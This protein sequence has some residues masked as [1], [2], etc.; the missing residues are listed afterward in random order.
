MATL[1]EAVTASDRTLVVE[2]PVAT[3]TGG[4]LVRLED[5]LVRFGGYEAAHGAYLGTGAGNTHLDF[6]RWRVV[7]GVEGTTAVSHLAGVDVRRAVEAVGSSED[8]TPP[9]PFTSGGGGL[10]PQWAVDSDGGLAINYEDT[11]GSV[12]AVQVN[13]VGDPTDYIPLLQLGTNDAPAFTI[14]S[15]GDADVHFRDS[16]V[17]WIWHKT[18]PNQPH[19]PLVKIGVDGVSLGPPSGLLQ[20]QYGDQLYVLGPTGL[21]FQIVFATGAVLL[22]NLPTSDPVTAGQL[23]NSAGTLKVSAGPPP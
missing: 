22:P 19:A 18:E 12:P 7:R 23:W 1:A 13:Y 8:L 5:E 20:V 2:D 17:S 11:Q 3:L 9:S 14:D 15:T 10:P 4:E 6:T 21:V 16:G